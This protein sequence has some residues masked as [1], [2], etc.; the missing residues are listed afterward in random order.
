ME[1]VFFRPCRYVSLL[2]GKFKVDL[3]YDFHQ[4]IQRSS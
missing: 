4:A 2:D 1:F 3:G